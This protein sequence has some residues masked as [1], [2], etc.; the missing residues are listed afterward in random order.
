MRSDSN[1]FTGTKKYQVL[2]GY[3]SPAHDEYVAV[4]LGKETIA[5]DHR[6]EKRDNNM[7]GQGE[8]EEGRATGGVSR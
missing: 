4:K 6:Y 5:I 1:R 2:A 7:R 8:R 3:L